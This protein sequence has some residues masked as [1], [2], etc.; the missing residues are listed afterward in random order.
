MCRPIFDLGARLFDSRLHSCPFPRLF[1]VLTGNAIGKK[2]EEN[3]IIVSYLP[4]SHATETFSSL[5]ASLFVISQ[6]G[7]AS[8]HLHFYMAFSLHQKQVFSTS[9]PPLIFWPVLAG[10]RRCLKPRGRLSE[11]GFYARPAVALL[12]S[13]RMRSRAVSTPCSCP[14]MVMASP[15]SPL[16]LFLLGT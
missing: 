6:V 1:L 16:P 3:S 2:G 11:R 12:I 15:S 7:S 9:S 5:G 14:T 10:S 4:Q 8:S 13:S